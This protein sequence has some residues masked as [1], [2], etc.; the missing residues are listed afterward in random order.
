MAEN[1]PNLEK[2]MDIDVQMHVSSKQ[3]PKTTPRHVVNKIAKV[4][5]TKNLKGS[6]RKTNNHIRP[7]ADFTA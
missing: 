2:E 6:K 7:S 5:N 1:L 3:V 4:K